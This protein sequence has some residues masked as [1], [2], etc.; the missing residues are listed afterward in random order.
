[1][2]RKIALGAL[3]I[4]IIA[5]ALAAWFVQNQINTLRSQNSELQAQNDEL[6]D[7]K[8]DLQDQISELQNQT[9]FLQDRIQE[10]LNENYEGSPVRI[11][12]V[13]YLGGF[14]PIVGMLIESKVNVTVLNKYTYPL[15]GLT[16]TTKFLQSTGNESGIPSTLKLD[17][18]QAGE[19]R[20]IKAGASW[21]MYTEHITLVVTLKLGDFVMDEVTG[22]YH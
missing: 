21:F 7:Q 4:A 9:G 12:S 1:M 19:S 6:Q 22:H 5:L 20:E 11:V 18:L 15:S 17:E 16:L 2:N 14:S 10:K 8:S 3:L 13:N